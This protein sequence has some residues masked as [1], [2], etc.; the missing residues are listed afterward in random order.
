MVMRLYVCAV[1][2]AAL[3]AVVRAG[4]NEPIADNTLGL[5]ARDCAANYCTSKDG[6]ELWLSLSQECLSA[7]N[8]Y[9][10]ALAPA[11][12]QTLWGPVAVGAASAV[13]GVAGLAVGFASGLRFTSRSMFP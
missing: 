1:A 2:A 13:F 8:P 5:T 4:T 3:L 12:E 11:S 6:L 7:A 9:F 10:A